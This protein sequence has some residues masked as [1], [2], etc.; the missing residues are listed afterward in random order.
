MIF[1]IIIRGIIPFIIMASIAVYL[2][3]DNQ[4]DAARSTFITGIIIT[5]VSSASVIYDLDHLSLFKRSMIH[6]LTMI[7]T[8]YPLLLISG[9]FE[10]TTFTDYIVIFAI[11][12]AV[13]LVL[14]SIM[15]LIV[16]S[17]SKLKNG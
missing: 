2:Y 17:V 9:W 13:G 16:K 10:T 6:I 15:F 4:F 14:W 7:I 12:S 5:I 8:V 1:Q 11:F 3:Y